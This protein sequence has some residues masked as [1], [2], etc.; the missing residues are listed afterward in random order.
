MRNEPIDFVGNDYS[1]GWRSVEE[2]ILP[3]A[4]ERK[5]GF[6]AHFTFDRGRLFQRARGNALA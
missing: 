1:A 2:R 3:L 4:M 6:M 5:I